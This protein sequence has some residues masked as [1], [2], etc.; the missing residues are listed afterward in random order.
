MIVPLINSLREPRV[1]AQ[2]WPDVF[3]GPTPAT[4]PADCSVCCTIDQISWHSHG[5]I[6]PTRAE[7]RQAAGQTNNSVGLSSAMVKR[8]LNHYAVPFVDLADFTAMEGALSNDDNLVSV[9]EDMGW[10]NTNHIEFSGDHGYNGG[11]RVCYHGNE[12]LWQGGPVFYKRLDPIGDGR[13]RNG[14]VLAKQPLIVRRAWAQAAM[15]ALGEFSAIS[16]VKG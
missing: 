14:V 1:R 15:T 16:V 2:L 9:A 6:V 4:G 8:A 7:L 5:T 11:H 3:G 10:W 12:Q 13:I